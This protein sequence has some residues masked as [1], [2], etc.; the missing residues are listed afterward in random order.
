MEDL[1][2]PRKAQVK[3]LGIEQ[4]FSA[5]ESL[6]AQGKADE[7]IELQREW[8]TD[9]QHP[10]RQLVWFNHGSALQAAGQTPAAMAAYNHCLQLQPGFAQAL[11][12][13]GLVCEKMGLREVA[14]THWA[15]VVGQ[16]H[17]QNKPDQA[18]LIMALN[19]MGRVQEDMRQYTAAEQ[20]LA[21][22]LVL[23]PGQIGVLQHWIYIR[24]KACAWPVYQGLPGISAHQQLMATSPLAMLAM[25]NDP[26]QQLLTAHAFV[27]RTYSFKHEK[28]TPA[29]SSAHSKIRLGYVSGDLCTHAVG[30]LMPDV[31]EAHDKHSFEV[32]AYDFSPEDGSVVRQRIKQAVDHWRRIDQ[33]S[34]AQVAEVIRADE[35]D[36]L[37][38]MHG[39]SAGARPGIFALRPAPHQGSYLGFIGT[40]AMPWIDFMVTDAVACPHT[41]QPYFTEH[42][43]HME[44]CFIPMAV[45]AASVGKQWTRTELGLP[46]QAFVMAAFC[47]TYKINAALL[48]SWAQIVKATDHTV[49]WLIDDNDTSTHN[50]QAEFLQLGVPLERVV[51]SKRLG[52][53]DYQKVLRMA[54]LFLDS[55]PYN[56][57]STAKDI[58]TAGVPLLTLQ[59]Q[60]FVSRMASSMLTHMGLH[61]LIAH[62]SDQYV[63]RAIGWAQRPRAHR[64]LCAQLAH[65]IDSHPHF[66]PHTFTPRLESALK[67]WLA[68]RAATH[69]SQTAPATPLAPAMFTI[70]YS[71][72][73]MAGV[74]SPMKALD[75]RE[76][77][78]PDW[79]EYWP[80]RHFLLN[81]TLDE[82]RLYGFFSP[83]F[84]EKTSLSPQALQDWAMDK[85]QG[86]DVMLICPQAD[87]GAFFKNVFVQNELFDPGFLATAQ[88]FVDHIGWPVDLA[89]LVMDARHIVFSNY[90][91][92]KPAFWR[93]WLAITEALFEVCESSDEHAADLRAQL[94]TETTYRKVHRKVFLLER[95]ASLLLKMEPHWQVVA[96]NTFDCAWSGSR[97]HAYPEDAVV[98]DALKLA[99]D[100]QGF[101]QYMDAFDQHIH[102]LSLKLSV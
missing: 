41:L 79:Q 70:A 55:F 58:L 83:R 73:T 8:L 42:L 51:F 67:R 14:L 75:N 86:A 45:D 30:L 36:I 64:A 96:Y 74:Q 88:A 29:H 1:L 93:R 10:Q 31:L 40:T 80:M 98:C 17:M 16:R 43:L 21:Q 82:Q 78:R 53:G 39:L 11:I 71:E 95:L 59:G 25:V 44:G 52:H 6:Q 87:M 38:D 37:I 48:R 72:P 97:L 34:D 49:L 13:L 81:Q 101:G 12:N 54:D 23:D 33:L 19:H 94:L 77:L 7:A 56:C 68:H 22:S 27:G 4:L 69:S 32:F 84:N 89:G 50:L 99:H 60:T 15:S 2:M 66:Q 65:A 92:A 26:V 3:A 63:D 76:N 57:G 28:P 91:L 35:I 46:E 9:S 100:Q 24:Q 61:Q 47:N 102:R 5:C 85:G 90:V 18:M 62:T 20:T